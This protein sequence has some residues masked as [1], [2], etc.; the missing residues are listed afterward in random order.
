MIF[1]KR[2]AVVTGSASGLGLGIAQFL[3]ERGVRV[4]LADI[5]ADRLEVV[6]A[7]ISDTDQ[8]PPIF[9]AADLAIRAGAEEV[10]G[11]AI[12]EFGGLDILVNNAGGGVI[13]PTLAHTEATLRETMDRNLWTTLYCTLAAL[14]H[15]VS[16][17]YGRVVNLGAES[18]RNGLWQHAVYSA[19]K[20]GVHGF[21]AGLAREFAPHKIT[22]NVVA[23]A[24]VITPEHRAAMARM[25]AADLEAHETFLEQIRQTIP[26]GRGGE[27]REVAAT[28]AFLASDDAGYITGQVIS[29]NGGSS[30]L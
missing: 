4:C 19:A 7:T 21:T 9:L 23:P 12:E 20:G 22:F 28:A 17:G 25:P 13:R 11:T 29:V 1:E 26:L 15:M 8:G 16:R 18:V 27:V 10:I 5:A 6:R 14:P 2:R 3:S 24:M 30:M